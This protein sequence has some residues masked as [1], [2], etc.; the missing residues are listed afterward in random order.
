MCWAGGTREPYASHAATFVSVCRKD[1]S[2]F[3][4]DPLTARGVA[5]VTLAYDV[6]PKGKDGVAAGLGAG[7]LWRGGS[8]R[9]DL[10]LPLQA[11]WTTRWTR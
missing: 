11:P 10:T 5:V 2:A 9:W 3:M 4:V 8:P 1:A 7:G 6:A